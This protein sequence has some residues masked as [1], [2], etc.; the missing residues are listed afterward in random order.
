[1]NH[2]LEGLP[3]SP[4]QSRAEGW[5]KS[6][7]TFVAFC[8]PIV[9]GLEY[10]L[11]AGLKTAGSNAAI[12]AVESKIDQRLSR[13]FRKEAEGNWEW[14]AFREVEGE[15]DPGP[16]GDFCVTPIEFDGRGVGARNRTARRPTK[17]KCFIGTGIGHSVNS[18]IGKLIIEF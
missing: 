16:F 8:K 11:F 9:Q 12:V 10:I 1:M 6:T 17:I 13:P 7:P 5:L 15:F 18:S 2:D 14:G 3:V 4:E